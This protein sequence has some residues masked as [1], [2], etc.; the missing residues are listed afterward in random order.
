MCLAWQRSDGRVD[1][2]GGGT[3]NVQNFKGMVACTHLQ[4]PGHWSLTL[5]I[6]HES[7]LHGGRGRGFAR[8]DKSNASMCYTLM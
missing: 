3:A 1:G 4:H 8:S 7:Q 2:T 6:T 5:T